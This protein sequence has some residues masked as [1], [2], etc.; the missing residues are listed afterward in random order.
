MKKINGYNTGVASEYYIL[1]LLYRQGYEAYITSGNKK[2]VDIR[3][4]HEERT[5]SIDVKAV[6]GYSSLIV[7]NVAV[8]DNHFVVFVIYNNKFDDYYNKIFCK[9]MME[10]YNDNQINTT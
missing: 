1:S 3:V 4:A 2:S 5:L 7:N 9:I 8:K 6:Q 10:N